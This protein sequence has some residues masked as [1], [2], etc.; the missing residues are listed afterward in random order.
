MTSSRKSI[1]RAAE[2]QE[3]SVSAWYLAICLMVVMLGGVWAANAIGW[4]D[5]GSGQGQGFE[6]TAVAAAARKAADREEQA[7]L[8]AQQEARNLAED[9]ARQAVVSASPVP[10]ASAQA[11]PG[12]VD[13]E[14]LP[15]PSN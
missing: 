11:A 8:A 10:T 6:K 2:L 1:E 7:R 12:P 15:K 3:S 5:I 13:P 14:S 4:L 9:S